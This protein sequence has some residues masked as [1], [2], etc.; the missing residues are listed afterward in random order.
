MYDK[1][2]SLPVVLTIGGHDPGGGAGIQADIEAIAANGCHAA[3]A[4]TCL[5]VQDSCN[6]SQLIPIEASILKDQVNAILGDCRVAIVKIGLIGSLPAAEAI[7]EFLRSHQTIPVVF[8]PVLAAGGGGELANQELIDYIR[9]ALIPLC[10]LLT[11][12]VPE[13][14]SLAGSEGVGDYQIIARRLL[15]LGAEA[16]LI[17][18]SHDP[19]PGTEIIHRLYRPD[20][21]PIHSRWQ[22]LAGEFHGSGCTLTSAIAA[23]MALGETMQAAVE[24]GLAYSWSAISNGFR[25]GRC[26]AIP[27]R[28]FTLQ[29][30]QHHDG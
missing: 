26:Q 19:D 27:E 5:T 21:A 10:R 30:G 20:T 15:A 24:Q 7:A 8:D 16:V 14:V 12:N 22:R 13:A 11:P 9:Q 6:V 3:T 25:T 29:R 18:G 23:R 17:T 28:L 4:L 2:P 1:S